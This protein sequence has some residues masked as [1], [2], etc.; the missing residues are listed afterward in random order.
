MAKILWKLSLCV[1]FISE[2]EVLT[3]LFGKILVVVRR[4][5]DFHKLI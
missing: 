3:A 1:P 5:E 4:R 2:I